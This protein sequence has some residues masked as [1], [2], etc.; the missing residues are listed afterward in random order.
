MSW[1]GIATN[2]CVSCENL[3]DAVTNG[4]FTLKNTIPSSVP[5]KYKQ[6]TKTEADFYVN[7]NTSNA[8]YVSKASNQLV[9][10]T[11]LTAP[12][13]GIIFVASSGLY[14]LSG[15][16]S[17]CIGTI[18][19]YNAFT[20]YVKLLFN[21]AGLNSGTVN[22]DRMYFFSEYI[23]ITGLSITSYGQNI[24]SNVREPGVFTYEGII[25]LLPGVSLN[26]TI[27]KFDGFGSG[28]TLRLAWSTSETGTFT[29][30]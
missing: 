12:A 13:S 25:G 6:I 28:T 21:S 5:A 27:D 8:G 19:N 22:S 20:V 15:P 7:I 10:K 17:T 26:V 16:S 11:D 2:Q 23:G 30:F 4:V 14:P 29:P 3:Q 18:Y 24:Y 9:I 1:A